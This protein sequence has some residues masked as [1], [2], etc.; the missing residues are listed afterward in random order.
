MNAS[1]YL[2]LHLKLQALLRHR[3]RL[4]RVAQQL[5]HKH[6]TAS[7]TALQQRIGIPVSLE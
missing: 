3:K 7:V 4:T 2:K 5:Q 6:A 1:E